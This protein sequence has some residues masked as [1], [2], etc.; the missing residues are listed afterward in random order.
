MSGALAYDNPSDGNTIILVIHQAIKIDTLDNNLL[1]P[2]QLRLNDVI[3]NET[4]RFLCRNVTDHSHSLIMSQ[5]D[6]EH[7]KFTL[8][9]ELFGVISG[10]VTRKPTVEEFE[11]CPRYVL[12]AEGPEYNPSTSAYAEQESAM[13]DF[14]GQLKED[15]SEKIERRLFGISIEEDDRLY[16]TMNFQNLSTLCISQEPETSTT[17]AGVSTELRSEGIDAGTL[18]KN[19]GIGLETAKKT[20]KVTTQRG[21]RTVVHP[22]LSRRFRTNDRQLRYRRLPIDLYTDTMKATVKSQQGNKVAQVFC[23]RNGWTRAFPLEKEAHAHEALSLLFQRDGAPNTMIMDGARAQ[24][25]GNFKKKLKEAHV[26]I[27]QIEP[28]SPWSNAAEGAIRELKRGTG[29]ELAR[30][31]CPKPLWDHCL[32]REAYVRSFTAHSISSLNGQVPETIISGETADIS[33]FAEFRWYETIKYRDSS[34]AFPEDKM[35]FGRDLGPAIDIG[36]AMTRK[37]L[38]KKGNVIYR[39]TVRSLTED[40]KMD[41]DEIEERKAFNK[42]ISKKLGGPLKIGQFKDDPELADM[43]TPSFLPYEDDETKPNIQPDMDEMDEDD[44]DTYDQYVGATVKLPI[45]DKF[46]A[47]KVRGRKR[48]L[49]G[50]VKGR[51]NPNPI[52]DT[53][54]YEVE[55]PDGQ[56]TEYTA[57][58]IA[59]SMYAQCDVEGNEF[60]LLDSIVD[61]H[62]DGDAVKMQDAYIQHGSNR[63]LRQT[64]KGWKLCVEWK[65]GSTSWERLADLKES[66]PIEVAE[67]A[68][69]KDIAQEPAFAWWVPYVLKKRK[70]IIAAVNKRYHKRTHKFGIEIPKTWDDAVRIDKENGNTLW[71][72]AI[73][74]EMKNV[75]VAFKPLE[76]GEKIPVGY[77][78]IKCHMVF[79]VKMED[80]RRKA[81]FVAGGHMTEVPMAATYSSVVSRDSV[82]IAFT[83]AAL[84]DLDVCTGDIEN[85]YLTAPVKEKIWCVLGKEFG[86]DAG[87]RALI[88]RAL[89]GLKTAGAAFRAHLADCMRHMGWTSCLADP[90][91]WL[92]AETRPSDG[93]KYYAYCLMYVD[94]ILCVHHD[95]KSIIY[96][97]NKY[98]KIKPDSIGEP[99]FYL[100]AKFSKVKL[101]NGVEAW[102]MSSSKYTQAA[103]AN[104]EEH[105]QK[106]GRKLG[107]KTPTPMVHG[108][109]PELDTTP[110][111]NSG[112]A[113]YYQSLVGI[114]R[115]MVEIGRVDIITEVSEM[116]SYLAMPREGH[117]DSVIHIY[118]YLKCH[119]NCRMIFDPTYPTIEQEQFKDNCDWKEMYGD[120]K[121]AIPPNAPKPRGKEVDLRLYVDSDHATETKTRRSRT[122]FLVY[123]NMAPII[124]YSKRQPTVE[125]SVF[126][127]EFV[128]MKNGIETV[129]GLRYKLRMMGIPISGPT[130][131]YC[132][133][134]S[135]VNNSQSPESTLKKKSNAICYHATRESVAMGESLVTHIPTDE[136]PADLCTKIL[137]GG[138]NRDH[139]VGLILTDVVDH[140]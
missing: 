113:N 100:G 86:S 98:F 62:K 111:L 104:V 93:F 1:C 91:V 87:K 53:R 4:P 114:L 52:L 21:I 13:V 40:E 60:L 47:G 14:R 85:A 116:S 135:V 82:R 72:D 28:H 99:K 24:I 124:W 77:Q 108:Y 75:Q 84:N 29:R 44:P 50:S 23:S 105:L 54:T 115:W 134:K 120:V 37:I 110:E 119:H 25:M 130:Y 96:Q 9:L 63:K 39:S 43:E 8:P 27:R 136:N 131:V 95:A 22:T 12:T 125:T 16:A 74:K 78:E 38:N 56:V 26:H 30:S 20:L 41:P 80:F 31:K 57:N 3:V 133:N 45:G 107:K 59:E 19:W 121:E 94:D 32:E 129:R 17:I 10:F 51:A 90:D 73:N 139:K 117:L 58:V 81:R 126:G 67:Y 68:M 11:T 103:V 7:E 5:D 138:M 34:I 92:R 79:D 18:A 64:T 66:Y 2:M 49:D 140:K 48:E 112:D 15:V 65:D 89:Y 88:V 102:G 137:Q 127:A 36:P 33:P 35:R 97:I 55:F 109:R 128:A 69:A 71:Q 42:I 46:V 101:S 76:D 83:M 132:D 118:S 70:R 106:T 123:L 122:G 6:N 61:H